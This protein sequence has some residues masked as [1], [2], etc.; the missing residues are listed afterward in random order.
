MYHRRIGCKLSGGIFCKVEAA[1]YDFEMPPPT[2]EVSLQLLNRQGIM[3]R[4]E[5]S[6]FITLLCQ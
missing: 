1:V 2:L 6:L 3:E 5:G 4:F